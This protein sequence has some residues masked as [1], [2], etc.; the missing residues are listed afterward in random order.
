[1]N[2]AASQTFLVFCDRNGHAT[3]LAENIL[4]R[5]FQAEWILDVRREYRVSESAVAARQWVSVHS[6]RPMSRSPRHD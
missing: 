3:E 6:G 4:A 1:M 5:I 2:G